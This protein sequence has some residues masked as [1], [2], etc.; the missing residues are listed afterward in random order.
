MKKIKTSSTHRIFGF[1]TAT[2][3]VIG[4]MIGTGIFF[5][6]ASLASIGSISILGWLVTAFGALCLAYVFS[7]LTIVYP[8]SGGPYTHS[9]DAFGNFAGFQMGWGYWIM[10]WTSNA[11][12]SIAFI[13]YL[14]LFFPALK[15]DRILSFLGALC[16]L[17]TATIVNCIGLRAG[18][19]VQLI[20][21]ILKVC[22]L[23][24]VPLAGI[25][26]IDTQNYFPT[27]QPDT[28]LF[29]GVSS[30][31]ALT[32]WAFIGLESATVPADSVE[33]PERTISRAT[34]FG[35][36]LVAIVYL[37]TTIV[38]FGLI[39]ANI[40]ASS[41]A[42]FVDAAI[43][44]FGSWVGPVIGICIL[45]SIYGGLNGWVLM[46]GQVPHSMAQ[47]GLFPK[48]FAKES[49]DGTPVFALI[50]SSVSASI[51]MFLTL[52]NTLADRIEMVVEVGAVMTIFA[53]LFSALSTYV[54]F[55]G[56]N[57]NIYAHL[58][59]TLHIAILGGAL[60]S[61]FAIYGAEIRTL[62]YV[63][64]GFIIGIPIYLWGRR[65]AKQIVKT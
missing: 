1:W 11:A 50:I 60:Y 42:P 9:K 13:S 7:R 46:Q 28:S 8:K 10:G 40:L 37:F 32:L 38:L 19:R 65:D 12:V 49:K 20:T 61:I 44:I 41:H 25:F 51:L 52:D 5:L 3:L 35:T 57:K 34:L 18:G 62:L 36:G 6:P 53:Y 29:H 59:P 39:P 31:F 33:N 14:A 26:F 21:S 15:T 48:A 16:V 23:I 56:S 47:E 22:P 43:L 58:T 2:S 63:G 55:R 17:W 64:V 4:N 30:A 24:I 45:I 54:L 27:H